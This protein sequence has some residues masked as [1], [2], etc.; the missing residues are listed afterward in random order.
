MSL[1]LTSCTM[2][3]QPERLLIKGPQYLRTR[4][5]SGLFAQGK[6]SAAELLAESKSQF[7]SSRSTVD[8]SLQQ[9]LT[10]SVGQGQRL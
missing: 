9:D 1:I 2:G 4:S 10:V 7:Y 5:T 6:K 3:K 8:L